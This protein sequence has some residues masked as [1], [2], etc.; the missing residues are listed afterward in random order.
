[1]K[2]FQIPAEAFIGWI[3]IARPGSILGPQQFYLPQMEPNYIHS[4]Q[5]AQK[6]KLMTKA[7][8]ESPQDKH[9]AMY[10][11]TNQANYLI[12]GK[13]RN[14][15]TKACN[16]TLFND[17][18]NES[19]SNNSPMRATLPKTSAFDAPVSPFKDQSSKVVSMRDE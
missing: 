10:G 6:S 18:T 13:G 15:E 3:R 14:S 11:E 17:R 12:N 8:N 4:H 19:M 1:M 2:H 16:R 9:K 7:L 5:S